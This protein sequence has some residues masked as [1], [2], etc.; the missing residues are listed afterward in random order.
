MAGRQRSGRPGSVGRLAGKGTSPGTD[1]RLFSASAQNSQHEKSGAGRLTQTPAPDRH[2]DLSQMSDAQLAHEKGQLEVRLP[3]MPDPSQQRL[4]A[5]ARLTA[6]EAVQAG[7]A[8]A[9]RSKPGLYTVETR[10]GDLVI[11]TAKVPAPNPAVALVMV[12]E[13]DP[14]VEWKFLNEPEGAFWTTSDM[15]LFY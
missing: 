11:C 8:G 14:R 5:M 15:A 4:T 3:E 2:E 7:R 12:A 9:G 13:D 6:I 10:M 1:R